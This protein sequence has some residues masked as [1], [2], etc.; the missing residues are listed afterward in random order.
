MPDEFE[1][2]NQDGN[3]QNDD[4]D[5]ISLGP[6]S[7]LI[8]AV[9][10]A[11][12]APFSDAKWDVATRPRTS[13]TVSWNNIPAWDRLGKRHQTP[14]L[15]S[16]VNELI[17]QDSWQSGNSM[18]FMLAGTGTRQAETADEDYDRAALL[19]IEYLEP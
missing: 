18:N 3:P 13:A 8:S 11:N 10:S 1:D 4:V 15:T 12:A 2:L 7:L 14:D 19:V 6:A 9:A 16:I 5:D 17:T